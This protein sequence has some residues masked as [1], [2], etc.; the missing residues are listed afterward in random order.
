MIRRAF[1]TSH[2][3]TCDARPGMEIFLSL[4]EGK[5]LSDLSLYT[6]FSLSLD[7]LVYWSSTNSS[8]RVDRCDEDGAARRV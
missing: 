1:S 4:S 2:P 7:P 8:S 6:S 5:R 3:M